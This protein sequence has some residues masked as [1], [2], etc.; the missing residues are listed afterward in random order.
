MV[1]SAAARVAAKILAKAK[2]DA[3]NKAY[4]K[5]YYLKKSED[6]KAVHKKNY[7]LKNPEKS[8][9]QIRKRQ[10][11]SRA[12][13]RERQRIFRE[14][15]PDY[16]KKYRLKNPPKPEARNEINRKQ[17]AARA[18]KRA[19]TGVVTGV[20]TRGIGKKYMIGP[21]YKSTTKPKVAPTPGIFAVWTREQ[22]SQ[23]GISSFL[24]GLGK[25]KPIT[26][27]YP[28]RPITKLNPKQEL[29]MAVKTP[30]KKRKKIESADEKAERIWKKMYGNTKVLSIAAM[31]GGLAAYT[32][33]NRGKK[34][35]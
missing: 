17:R 35:G 26:K 15:N 12:K 22:K 25:S 11:A 2:R 27:D 1:I 30:K 4:N 24:K 6:I 18:T 34:R 33:W 7:R 3:Y 29:I 20:R 10:E 19:A 21:I 32:N 14:K 8:P 16:Q 23:G 31:F 5:A 9:E 28:R 13:T